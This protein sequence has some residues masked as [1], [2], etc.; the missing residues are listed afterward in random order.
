MKLWIG[1]QMIGGRTEK[2]AKIGKER[3]NEDI[4][5]KLFNRMRTSET[6]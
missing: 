1:E 2:R 3:G 5:A 6:R 4:S